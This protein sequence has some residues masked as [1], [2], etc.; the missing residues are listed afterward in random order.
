MVRQY[1]PRSVLRHL[2]LDLVRAFLSR[3]SITTGRDW[4]C[5]VDGDSQAIWSADTSLPP[6]P[7]ER[8]EQMFRHVHEMATHA[9]VRA[10]VA[11]AGF[12][13]HVDVA[14]I[15]STLDGH[16][17]RALWALIHYPPAFHTA[18]LLLSAASPYGRYWNLTRG[19]PGVPADTSGEALQ[20]LRL[21]VTALYREQGRGLR[22][23]VESHERDGRLYVFLFLDDYTQTHVGHNDLGTLVRKPVRPAFEVVFVYHREAGARPVRRRHGA[24]PGGR[25]RRVLR[26]RAAR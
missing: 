3:D 4:D 1:S 11:E 12:R 9:G 15:I 6:G 13:G 19:T 25:P 2:P 23:S 20:G 5:L 18:R 7:R 10:L 24:V 26:A 14:D 17:A 16:H 21:A 8:V 22:S